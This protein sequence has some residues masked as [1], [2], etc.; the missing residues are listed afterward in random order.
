MEDVEIY[1]QKTGQIFEKQIY[2]N[3]TEIRYVWMRPSHHT[4]KEF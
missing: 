3:I 4:N 2:S 1:V